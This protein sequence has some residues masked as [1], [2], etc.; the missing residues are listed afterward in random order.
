MFNPV[1]IDKV[2]VVE[3]GSVIATE[4]KEDAVARPELTSLA[5]RKV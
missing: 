3:S 5:G 2:T 4:E 1:I